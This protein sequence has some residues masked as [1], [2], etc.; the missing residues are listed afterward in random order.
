[1]KTKFMKPSTNL[2]LT[3]CKKAFYA[4]QLLV[5]SASIP[6]LTYIGMNYQSAP[7]EKTIKVEIKA[8]LVKTTKGTIY[9]EKL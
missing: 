8:K 4:I 2:I 5:I 9:L 6:T 3:N 1:M 7:K